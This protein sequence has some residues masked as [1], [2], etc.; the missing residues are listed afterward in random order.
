METAEKSHDDS[1]SV[2]SKDMPIDDA[3]K[4]EN[5]ALSYGLQKALRKT[6]SKTRRVVNPILAVAALVAALSAV[7]AESYNPRDIVNFV[8]AVM[9]K[10]KIMGGSI[11][12]DYRV[13]LHT[14]YD[15]SEFAFRNIFRQMPIADGTDAPDDYLF[16][17]LRDDKAHITAKDHTYTIALPVAHDPKTA[18]DTEAVRN[19]LRATLLREA[20]MV[21]AVLIFQLA[22]FIMQA[23]RESATAGLK[24]ALTCAESKW[25][26]YFY[27]A[28]LKP[29]GRKV[30]QNVQA[31]FNA[32]NRPTDSDIQSR[33]CAI[34]GV[35]PES[36]Q[37]SIS[38]AV[39]QII[40]PQP[41]SELRSSG[42]NLSSVK[43]GA[44]GSSPSIDIGLNPSSTQTADAT[45]LIRRQASF[46]QI[47]HSCNP[48][49]A[50]HHAHTMSVVSR[51][52]NRVDQ[53]MRAYLIRLMESA[54]A[55]KNDPTN[56]GPPK[57]AAHS[58]HSV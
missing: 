7:A 23:G 38:Q 58:Q 28:L 21:C 55:E 5:A 48:D 17:L 10:H 30:F 32:E 39:N 53:A 9:R 13:L 34:K 41:S 25:K 52:D 54:S 20:P 37:L 46:I 15:I 24:E 29:E 40:D 47:V 18:I 1:L 14:F 44:G 26:R 43:V 45:E 50:N 36:V 16:A 11:L 12:G 2:A 27:L 56:Q 51:F 22:S 3:D 19:S 31:H 57:D 6:K 33:W 49:T 35:L 8:Q 42:L 4:L